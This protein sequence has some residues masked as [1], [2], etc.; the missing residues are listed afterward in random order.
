MIG[1]QD[2]TYPHVS[3]VLGIQDAPYPEKL[4]FTMELRPLSWDRFSHPSGAGG[5]SRETFYIHYKDKLQQLL[6]LEHRESFLIAPH[7][8][9]DTRAGAA[10]ATA[11]RALPPPQH[12]SSG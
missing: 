7:R 2:A 10:G 8:V 1:L 5:G 6:W 12:V 9:K 3:I 4:E 11:E